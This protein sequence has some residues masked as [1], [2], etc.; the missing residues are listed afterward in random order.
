MDINSALASLLKA[1][2]DAQPGAEYVFVNAKTGSPFG[3]I[4]KAFHIAC[5]RAK[6]KGFRFHDLRHAFASRLIEAGVAIIT[7]RDLPGHSSVKLTERYTYSK[8]EQKKHAVELLVTQNRKN[9]AQ[10]G[11]NSEDEETNDN[12]IPLYSAN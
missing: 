7:V 2:R 8:N 9:P 4:E 5:R 11:H 3:E 1:L 12:V 10:I 6:I